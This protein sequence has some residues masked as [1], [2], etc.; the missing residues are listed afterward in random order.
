MNSKIDIK[1]SN[2]NIEY[3]NAL[4]FMEKKIEKIL[5]VGLKQVIYVN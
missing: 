2:H 4:N 1:T 5:K 3:I